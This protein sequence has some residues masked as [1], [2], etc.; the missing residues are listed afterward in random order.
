M[1]IDIIK[2]LALCA[3][4]AAGLGLASCEDFLTITP[5]DKIVEEAQANAQEEI[6][7]SR[8]DLENLSNEEYELIYNALSK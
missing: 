7:K 5:K 6:E 1:K 4:V 2:K 8:V 3:C